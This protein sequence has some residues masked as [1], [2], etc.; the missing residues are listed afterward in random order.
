MW[1]INIF[2]FILLFNA[3]LSISLCIN[4]ILKKKVNGKIFFA[5]L[6]LSLFFWSISDSLGFATDNLEMKILFAKIAYI[7]VVSTAPLYFLF[8]YYFL[9]G[10][11]K[12]SKKSFIVVWI[13]PV[14]IFILA[15]TNEYNLLIWPTVTIVPGTDSK[16][17][18]FEHGIGVYIN[19]LYSYSLILYVVYSLVKIAFLYRQVYRRQAIIMIV[20]TLVPLC[21]NFIYVFRLNP[22]PSLDL[23]P[24]LFTISG[25][26]ITWGFTSYRFLDT[27]PI[28]HGKLFSNMT[29]SVLVLDGNMMIAE[30]NPS[31]ENLFGMKG[32]TGKSAMEVLSGYGE[33][34]KISKY[35]NETQREIPIKINESEFWFDVRTCPLYDRYKDIIGI[36]IVIRDI[37]ESKKKENIIRESE[38]NLKEI[39]ATK[40]KFFSIIAH[41]LKSP[42]TALL[43]LSEILRNDF[44]TLSEDQKKDFSDMLYKSA[45]STYKLIE[46][47]LEWTQLQTG[48]F[49]MRIE[50]FDL[51][52]ISSEICSALIVNAMKKNI[53]INNEIQKGTIVSSD[54]NMLKLLFNNLISN[55]IKFSYK[56]GKIDI[57]S[58]A[59]DEGIE[60]TVADTGIGISE[61]D[62]AKLFRTDISFSMKGTEKEEGTGLGLILC[63]EIIEKT[64][65]KIWVESEIGKGSKFKFLIPYGQTKQ[66]N[67]K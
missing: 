65:G 35:K 12:L 1:N 14:I 43:G 37:T 50:E 30:V 45:K 23:T 40:D 33:L 60:V 48:K 38:K 3:L 15:A 27:K 7:G 5:L 57:L 41:D 56:G 26:M 34:L 31:F 2:S 21:G 51:K 64:G 52:D 8:F 47:L 58:S 29:D 6:M 44:D 9:Q 24:F 39:V 19:M 28:A 55:A 32:I 18:L 61:K 63:K 25:F 20:A 11:K 62:I 22:Y 67:K 36:I 42:F 46:N 10:E 66:E 4:I 59:G 16:M 49:E 54:K 17:T 13:I 53:V